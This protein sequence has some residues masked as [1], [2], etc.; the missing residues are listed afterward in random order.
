[1]VGKWYLGFDYSDYNN[2]IGGLVDYGFDYYYGISCLFDQKDY[3]FIENRYVVEFLIED[4][5][6]GEGYGKNG[7]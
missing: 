1:M 5:E 4:I 2:F 7:W 6:V 3:Y